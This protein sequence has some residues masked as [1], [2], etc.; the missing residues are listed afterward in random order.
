VSGIVVHQSSKPQF[1]KR[2]LTRLVDFRKGLNNRVSPVLIEDEEVADI[3]NFTYEQAGTL[4]RRG[5]YTRRFPSSF[6][7]GPVR[8]L[9]NYRTENGRSYLVFACDG[10][11][12]YDK[13]NF[14]QLYDSQAEWDTAGVMRNSVTTTEVVGDVKAMPG[15]LSSPGNLVPGSRGGIAGGTRWHREKVWQGNILNISAVTD[16]T[17]G[18]IVQSVTLPTGTTRTIETRTS[19]DGV[20]FGAWTALGVGDTI[21]GVGADN[22]LQPRVRFNST[23]GLRASA[24]S[25]QVFFDQ[26]SSATQLTTGLS[27]SA[28]FDWATQND[29][30]WIVNGEDANRK[31]DGTTFG[32]MGGTPPQGKF[33]LN[34]KNRLF[35]AGTSTNRSRL[36]F[37]DVGDPETWGALSFIDVGKGDGDAITGLGILLD[38]LII[39]KDNSVWILSGDSATNFE[40]RRATD[41]GG[42]VVKQG[43]ALM[44]DTLGWMGKD[45]VRFFDGV[46]SAIASDKIETTLNGL[47]KRQLAQAA[48]VLWDDLY[49]LSVPE[50]ASLTNSVVLVYDT[51]RTAWTLFRGVP[52][53]E[54]CIFRQF[55]QDTLVFGSATQGQIHNWDGAATDDGTAI[56]SYVVT[57]ALTPAGG[58]EAPSL[59]PDIFVT[60]TEP[61]SLATSVLASFFKDLGAETA[62]IAL[63]MAAVPLNVLRAIP[64]TVGVSMARSFAVKLTHSESGKS[65]RIIAIDVRYSPKSIRAT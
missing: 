57:K 31:W 35:I 62:T 22:F 49:M 48:G 36:Y 53:G 63:T 59:I 16:K 19:P 33:I 23:L 42:A 28:R 64:S 11:I 58:V 37:S 39:T 52:A 17:T 12:F 24:H 56:T 30:L 55:N 44:R 4:T 15:T 29:T 14:T 47:N 21:Q 2:G 43:M 13:P 65:L 50:G 25:L 1:A 20:T 60:A 3:Q 61:S 32:T 46:K 10:K 34:H 6:G 18:R 40:L 8:G 54:W 51:N 38:T 5:G 45:G 9:Y 26:T 7:D 41:E 27:T